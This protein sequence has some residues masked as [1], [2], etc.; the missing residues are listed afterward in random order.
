[1]MS[2]EQ[3]SGLEAVPELHRRSRP[4][5]KAIASPTLAATVVIMK[6][7]ILMARSRFGVGFW[8]KLSVG[9]AAVLVELSCM[10]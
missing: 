2:V 8:V 9:D 7:R 1:M 4:L 3:H 6:N 5:S 10:L